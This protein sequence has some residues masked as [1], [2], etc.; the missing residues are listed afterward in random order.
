MS[1]NNRSRP[2]WWWMIPILLLT[3]YLGARFLVQ[4]VLW[5][6]E[7]FSYFRSGGGPFEPFSIPTIIQNTITFL[8]WPPG[9]FLSLA[10][11]TNTVGG[12]LFLDRL[13]SLFLG[14][15]TVS[16]MYRLGKVIHSVLFGLLVAL[17][18]STSAFFIYYLHEVRP[19]SLYIFAVTVNA[20]LYWTLLNN[21]KA[22]KGVAWGFALSIALSLY[23]H[24]IASLCVFSIAVYHILF[25][26]PKNLLKS[27]E[28]PDIKRKNWIRILRLGINGC[29]LFTP[30]LAIMFISVYNETF[31]ARAESL[32]LMLYNIGFTFTNGMVWLLILGL[33]TLRW[34]EKRIIRFIWVW[35]VTVMVVTILGNAYADFLFHPRHVLGISPM[36]VLLFAFTLLYIAQWKREV[37][38]L[39][40]GLWLGMGLLHSLSPLLFM[41][42]IPAHQVGIA[43]TANDTIVEMGEN[44]IADSDFALYGLTP[45]EIQRSFDVP[46]DNYLV[47]V[48]YTYTHVGAIVADVEF[49]SL[50]FP[51]EF[52]EQSPSARL[53]E[54]TENADTVWVFSLPDVPIQ[55]DLLALNSLLLDAEYRY[56]GA[57]VDRLDLLGTVYAQDVS[58]CQQI[59]TSCT[60]Q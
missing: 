22:G 41:E 55:A 50:L 2:L 4:D 47:N 53:Q 6:D 45:A 23:T 44:C 37:A 17:L 12:T 35:I 48:D 26:R 49:P 10:G 38:A 15:L 34:W 52:Y 39:L 57:V 7:W 9:Y 33:L 20:W 56:C 24:Y 5:M 21:P 54:A 60:S 31:A 58:M 16:A 14:V 40:L 27:K 36:V 51:E 18:L 43:R 1:D 13:L 3:T 42:R 8:S 28:D 46:L 25:E 59:I 29:M 11:W 32:L 19:Y 30:W